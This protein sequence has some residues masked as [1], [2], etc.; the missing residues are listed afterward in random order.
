MQLLMRRPEIAGFVSVAPPANQYDFSFLAPCPSS[1]LIIGGSA[2]R[3]V[4]PA[5]VA[6]LAD[7]L[8]QQ[9]GITITHKTIEGAGHFFDP[10][11]D[12][13]IATVDEYVR[14]R[15]AENSR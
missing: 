13:M 2:D 14:R 8:K 3:V 9:K 6:A 1:G 15:L 11:M 12:E 10:G 5:D 7:K 4:P